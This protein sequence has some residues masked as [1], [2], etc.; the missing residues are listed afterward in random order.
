MVF[1]MA[2]YISTVE[3]LTTAGVNSYKDIDNKIQDGTRNRTV[4]AT[5]M[6]ATSRYNLAVQLNE[7]NG[8][9]INMFVE[10]TRISCC[11]RNNIRLKTIQSFVIQ[12]L[13][14]N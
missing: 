10:A 9:Q 7:C 6:N 13:E 1:I 8:N 14:G 12:K 11:H 2:L 5:N 4:A 3:N